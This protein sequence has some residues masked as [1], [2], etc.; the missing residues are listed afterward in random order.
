MLKLELPTKDR[1]KE[2]R[3]YII[4]HLKHKSN[5]NGSGGL[6]SYDDYN[7]W[8][9]HKIREHNGEVIRINHVSAITYFAI[10]EENR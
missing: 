10:N 4:E 2:A 7:L 6:Y 3:L 9:N 1:E 8:V 5:I